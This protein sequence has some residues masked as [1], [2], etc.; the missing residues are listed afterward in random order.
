MKTVFSVAQ[1]NRYVK[2]MLDN[3]ALLAGLFV[4]GEIS[5]F[6]AHS[7]G[8]FYFTMK[9]QNA[10]IS[11]VM[12]ASHTES[13][14]FL[15]KNGMTVVAFGR[16]SLYE[17]TGQYRLYAEFMEPAGVGEAHLSVEQLGKKLE[18]E[19]L[20]DPRRKREIPNFA[21]TIAVVTSP[22]GAAIQDIIKTI[23]ERN[24]AV[25]IIIA[26]A[27]VQGE[28]AASDIVRALG[29]VNGHGEA[30]VIILGRGGGSVEDL[31]AF[32]EETV[33]RAIVASKIPVISAVGHETDFSIADSVAD[34]RA[35]TPTA[36]AQIAAFDQKSAHA[37]LN[38]LQSGL[39]R[40]VTENLR[41]NFDET[42]FFLQNLTRAANE[43]LANE[44]KTLAHRE[45]LLEKVSPYAAW[46]RGFALTDYTSVKDL[47]VGQNIKITFSDGTAIAKIKT[48]DE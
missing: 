27:V 14:N 42:K 41:E 38:N 47:S 37:H 21:K 34:F 3:D 10:A 4:E 39:T 1:V 18:A 31:Q 5:N 11:A 26:P 46:K 6:N 2:K 48:I 9:D 12:F 13:I 44:W 7:S 16:L 30:D 40:A 33:A 43:R 8:H 15:P 25:K 35:A 17:K 23:R 36:A 32:N 45:A 22:T 29:E 19:G 20:L 24:R 28:N